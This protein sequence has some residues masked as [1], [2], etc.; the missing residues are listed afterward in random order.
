M[1]G[2]AGL[3]VPAVGRPG[4]G[5]P[6][7]LQSSSTRPSRFGGASA[8]LRGAAPT[9][10]PAVAVWRWVGPSPGAAP[11]APHP[12]M[13]R[14]V[15]AVLGGRVG[16][17]RSA[18]RPCSG[19]AEAVPEGPAGPLRCAEPGA[20]RRSGPATLHVMLDGPVEQRIRRRCEGR[21]GRGGV[22]A[23]RVHE[24]EQDAAEEEEQ[25]QRDDADAVAV[26]ERVSRRR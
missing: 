12:D 9:A 23:G 18:G 16:N 15:V 10:P 20:A 7:R 21:A 17:G 8:G 4:L 2:R 24:G 13:P 25:H 14:R 11:T 1:P 5:W 26:G 22:A 19:A 3:V 6:H